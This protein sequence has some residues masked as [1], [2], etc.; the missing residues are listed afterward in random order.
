M[1]R[2]HL[3]AAAGA[4]IF[5]LSAA[6]ALAQ[7]TQAQRDAIRSNCRSDYM[8]NCSGVT[9][10]GAEALQCLQRNM[11]KLSSSCQSAVNAISPPPSGPA[12]APAPKPAAEIGRAHV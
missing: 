5:G 7:P 4:L 1:I 8:S 10:G 3:L 6:P 11:S 12:A 9:P 2:T